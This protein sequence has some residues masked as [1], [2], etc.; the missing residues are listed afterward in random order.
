MKPAA[1]HALAEAAEAL[2]RLAREV[3]SERPEA[4]DDALIPVAEA[5]RAR[6]PGIRSSFWTLH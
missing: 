3:A 2:A 1:L 6:C 5:S 4:R